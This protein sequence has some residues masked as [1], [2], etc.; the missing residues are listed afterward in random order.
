MSCGHTSSGRKISW[1]SALSRCTADTYRACPDPAHRARAFRL[2]ARS[3]I[4]TTSCRMPA[5]DGELAQLMRY[6]RLL[7][8]RM[9]RPLPA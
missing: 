1:S 8:R 3:I 2:S 6:F 7:P 4:C 5:S 9:P